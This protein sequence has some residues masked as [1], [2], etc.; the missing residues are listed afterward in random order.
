ME[1]QR[2]TGVQT[3][4]PTYPSYLNLRLLTFEAL[5]LRGRAS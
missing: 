5:L 3:A 1:V 2:A 4:P